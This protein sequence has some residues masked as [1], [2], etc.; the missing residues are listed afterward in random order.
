MHQT[1][2]FQDAVIQKERAGNCRDGHRHSS[3]I[4]LSVT[5]R[6][7]SWEHVLIELSQ[8]Q[9]RSELQETPSKQCC[10]LPVWTKK[11]RNI[12]YLIL[13]GYLLY[14]CMHTNIY[15]HIYIYSVWKKILCSGHWQ[16]RQ[17]P[18]WILEYGARYNKNSQ[19]CKGK[20]GNPDTVA[21]IKSVLCNSSGCIVSV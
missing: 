7:D 12:N 1:W 4:S 13:T 20:Y 21:A 11:H 14:L 6:Q 8:A 19:H 17:K 5:V 10:P 9:N 18:S 15:I 16:L 3:E 2:A